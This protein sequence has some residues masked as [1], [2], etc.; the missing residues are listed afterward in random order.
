MHTSAEITPAAQQSVVEFLNRATGV[1]QPTEMQMHNALWLVAKACDECRSAFIASDWHKAQ[2]I[3]SFEA[4]TC[5]YQG[6]STRWPPITLNLH[7]QIKPD[8]SIVIATPEEL[9][10]SKNYFV[11]RVIADSRFHSP[12]GD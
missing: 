7:Y 6:T 3:H 9:P 4:L 2:G 5:Q 10:L 1:T 11:K 12:D 8:G